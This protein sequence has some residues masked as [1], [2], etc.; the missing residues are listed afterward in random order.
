MNPVPKRV[1]FFSGFDPRGASFY[2]RLF[3]THL[4]AYSDAT[5]RNLSI[6][7]R[8]RSED[9]LFSTW[10]INEAGSTLLEYYFFHWDDLVRRSWEIRPWR[11]LREALSYTTGSFYGEAFA[12]YSVLLVELC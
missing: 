1:Y 11:L 5:G 4:H 8:R 7:P 9:G 6:S 2:Y 3:T 12:L 10:D